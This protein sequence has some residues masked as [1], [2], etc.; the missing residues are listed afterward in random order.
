MLISRLRSISIL[1]FTAMVALQSCSGSKSA[2]DAKND[3][4]VFVAPG[5]VKQD[6]KKILVLARAEDAAKE[7]LV[8]DA[9]AKEFKSNG[10]KVV[11]SYTVVPP[12][13]LKDTVQLRAKIESEGFDG[14]IVL[15][16]LGKVGKTVDQY[17]Y[18]GTMYSV[19]YGATGVFDLETRDVS[20]GY[21][22]VDF[23]VAGKLG[24]QYRAGL[25]IGMSNG[26][27]AILQQLS[28]SCRKKL[29]N[30]RIL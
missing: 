14:A 5:Y 17:K 10:Y 22:Q 26:R 7:K 6:Y 8:E 28:I 9:V 19:F 18:S 12:E 20:T 27:E 23:F 2:T 11:P 24:T 4:S 29:V 25:P 13:L 21:V 30:D 1:L 16:W 15:T 3:P